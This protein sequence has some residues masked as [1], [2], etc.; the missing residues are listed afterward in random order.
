MEAYFSCFSQNSLLLGFSM[1]A[2][3]EAIKFRGVCVYYASSGI[4]ASIVSSFMVLEFCFLSFLFY[5]LKVE[6]RRN[7]LKIPRFGRK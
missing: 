7:G 1:L 3:K 6:E 2:R 4:H 5:L